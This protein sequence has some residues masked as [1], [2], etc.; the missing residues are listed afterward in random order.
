MSVAERGGAGGGKLDRSV[1]GSTVVVPVTAE[2]L[3]AKSGA[4]M[5]LSPWGGVSIRQ[6][7][8]CNSAL[9][10]NGVSCASMETNCSKMFF[11]CSKFFCSVLITVGGTFLSSI[12]DVTGLVLMISLTASSMAGFSVVWVVVVV[13]V[14]GMS[15]VATG[16]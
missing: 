12:T 14:D 9:G 5:L 15:G 13:D 11:F 2:L 10:K 1:V 8:W 7:E 6:S 16:C 4:G 3:A